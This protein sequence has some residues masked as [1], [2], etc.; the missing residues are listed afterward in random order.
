METTRR[1]F[2]GG[3][4]ATT[5]LVPIIVRAYKKLNWV[6]VRD[7]GAI[8]DGVANDTTAIQAA[9]DAAESEGVVYFPEG[10]YLRTAPVVIDCPTTITGGGHM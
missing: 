10:I 3:L 5:V 1:R 2:L 7:F 9:F 6:N 8:G 4:L